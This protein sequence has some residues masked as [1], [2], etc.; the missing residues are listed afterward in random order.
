VIV[1][2]H[3][4][5]ES[6]LLT[7]TLEALPEQ[8]IQKGSAMVAEDRRHEIVHLEAMR[9]VYLEPLPQVLQQ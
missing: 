6:D 5:K 3:A 1:G 4:D 8:T 7:F 2:N 9:H